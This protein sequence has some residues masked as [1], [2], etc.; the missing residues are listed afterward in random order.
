[1]EGEDAVRPYQDQNPS[2][3]RAKLGTAVNN[4]RDNGQQLLVHI[5]SQVVM[6]PQGPELVTSDSSSRDLDRRLLPLQDVLDKL[7][8]E[9]TQCLLLLDLHTV[10]VP[11]LGGLG[12]LDAPEVMAKLQT[13]YEALDKSNLVTFCYCHAGSPATVAGELR[14]GI[15]AY[16]VQEALNGYANS[17]NKAGEEDANITCEELANLVAARMQKWN[18]T[19]A[20][21]PNLP[22]YF[23]KTDFVIRTESAPRVGDPPAV[24]EHERYPEELARTAAKP[25]S[26]STKTDSAPAK[27]DTAP[28]KPEKTPVKLEDA[29]TKRD[30]AVAG[31]FH[32]VAPLGFRRWESALVRAEQRWLGGAHSADDKKRVL[33]D[34]ALEESRVTF[35]TYKPFRDKASLLRLP[36]D[37]SGDA[38]KGV[39]AL[40]DPALPK[41]SQ[42]LKDDE[43]TG[44]LTPLGPVL[45]ANKDIAAQRL[46]DTALSWSS[47]KPLQLRRLRDL[48][49]AAKLPNFAEIHYLRYLAGVSDE[50]LHPY[51]AAFLQLGLAAERIRIDDSRALP[52]VTKI[53]EEAD[54]KFH[55]LL[56]DM[57]KYEI[58]YPE[59]NRIA[60]DVEALTRTYGDIKEIARL[61]SIAFKERDACLAVLPHLAVYDSPD[62]ELAQSAQT[63]WSQTITH[64]TRLLQQLEAKQPANLT[65]AKQLEGTSDQVR[66]SREALLSAIASQPSI[67][68]PWTVRYTL[69][70][71]LWT[72]AQRLE[73]FKQSGAGEYPLVQESLKPLD[74]QKAV[75]LAGKVTEQARFTPTSLNKAARAVDLLKLARHPDAERLDTALS[76]ARNRHDPQTWQTLR[77]ALAGIWSNPAGPAD[78]QARAWY[79]SPFGEDAET[80]PLYTE[81]T[82]ADRSLRDWTADRYRLRADAIEKAN[83]ID[84]SHVAIAISYREL[85]TKVRQ[86]GP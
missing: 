20:L 69:L 18:D 80:D 42:S 37:V 11:W 75:L 55:K 38:A 27:S 76:E 7:H 74:R 22:R 32:L 68:P 61:V 9:N 15:F 77:Q 58:G 71:P 53:T 36:I 19:H 25:D 56:Q 35:L 62:P 26:A 39:A 51:L 66:K 65:W 49:T 1:M 40:L 2:G 33:S 54:G 63:F 3:I 86:Q 6:T 29:W 73:R 64:L 84:K 47:P 59:A 70:C 43:W 12:E 79:A 16:A 72:K 67:P 8:R 10:D 31:G 50:K 13:F 60:K 41:L 46:L 23:H 85:E 17:W 44:V 21:P 83:G 82:A 14:G 34:L 48:L 4:A 81:R 28:A 5:T 45:A 24:H 30:D 57:Y 78:P 52:F